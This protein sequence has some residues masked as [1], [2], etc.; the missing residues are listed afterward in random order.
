MEP[1]KTTGN[2]TYDAIIRDQQSQNIQQNND[3]PPAGGGDPQGASV[4]DPA[5]TPSVS[6][7]DP[8]RSQVN[9]SEI[10]ILDGFGNVKPTDSPA[11]EP[12]PSDPMGQGGDPSGNNT[13]EFGSRLKSLLDGRFDGDSIDEQFNYL[14]NVLSDQQEVLSVRDELSRVRTVN[15]ELLERLKGQDPELLSAI[16]FKKD[17]GIE[18]QAMFS[19]IKSL[20]FETLNPK[21]AIELADKLRYSLSEE[22]LKYKMAQKY[23]LG[24]D[25][26]EADR[27]LGEIE[28]KQ[29]AVSAVAYLK[30]LKGKI[31]TPELNY[32]AE[33][34]ET[35]LAQQFEERKQAWDDV[36]EKGFSKVNN[37]KFQIVEGVDIEMDLTPEDI[38]W[39]KDIAWE[40]AVEQGFDPANP[41][42]FPEIGDYV[43]S[44]YIQKHFDKIKA[45][46]YQRGL[47]DSSLKEKQELANPSALTPGN[48]NQSVVSK[49]KD[50]SDVIF[51]NFIN[52]W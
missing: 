36:V 19:R 38:E 16:Q 49:P 8:G 9:P 31:T 34:R 15:A 39:M 43:N 52:R 6:D 13:P 41:E 44:M 12:N 27:R 24:E 29:D 50:A 2:E 20:D 17:T 48:P 28:M 51:E 14:E 11:G 33:S 42:V 25:F 18:D 26:E 22:D 1:F 32:D 37:P 30:E 46:I 45:A 5:S 21:Q 23:K 47:N 3:Q 40:Y 7:Q 35:E 10:Q 4:S